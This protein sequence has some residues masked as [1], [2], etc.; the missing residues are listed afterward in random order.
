MTPLNLAEASI[1]R[2][3]FDR[4]VVVRIHEKD[5]PCSRSLGGRC[6]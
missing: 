1:R 4:N 6:T 5:V 2:L 3:T